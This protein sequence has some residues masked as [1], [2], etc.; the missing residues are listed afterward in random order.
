VLVEPNISLLPAELATV[1]QLTELSV[2]L[3][4]ADIILLLV[5]HKVFGLIDHKNVLTKVVIDTRGMF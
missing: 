1:G 2:A 4:M 5:D 3:D